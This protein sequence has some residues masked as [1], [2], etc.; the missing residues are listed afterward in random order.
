MYLSLLS[1]VSYEGFSRLS[2]PRRNCHGESKLLYILSVKAIHLRHAGLL[3]GRVKPKAISPIC[4]PAAWSTVGAIL[5]NAD[6]N[7]TTITYGNSSTLRE[8]PDFLCLQAYTYVIMN[9]AR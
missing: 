2:F 1:N 4:S 7:L 8:K 9:Y 5:I 6:K 3:R